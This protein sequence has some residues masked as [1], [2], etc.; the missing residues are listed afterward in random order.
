MGLA[1]T[2]SLLDEMG[3][4][5]HVSSTPGEG[6][7]FT[8]IIRQANGIAPKQSKE[9]F[10]KESQNISGLNV[11]AVDDTVLNL[12]LIDKMLSKHGVNVKSVSSGK[13][14]ID[15]AMTHQYDLILLDHMMPE[16]DGL[17]VFNSIKERC[18]LN[19]TTPI[20][21]LTA[22]AMTGAAKEYIDMGFDDYISK[23]ING[24]ELISKIY[25]HTRGKLEE[26]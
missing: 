24:Q 5:I 1:I 6:S 2:K 9:T 3:G 17:E 20:I 11:L 25:L 8:M 14:A 15:D 10:C 13:E 16:M 22:N 19:R 4:S 12:T 26:V 18:Y 7:V 23:P 21:M